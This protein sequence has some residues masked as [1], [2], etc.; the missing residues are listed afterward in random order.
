[1]TGY[2]RADDS[3]VHATGRSQTDTAVNSQKLFETAVDELTSLVEWLRR[4][5]RQPI[6]DRTPAHEGTEEHDG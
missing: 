3:S 2:E 4:R 6:Q 5:D 1:M